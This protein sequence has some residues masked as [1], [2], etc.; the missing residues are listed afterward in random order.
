MDLLPALRAF[1]H[2]REAAGRNPDRPCGTRREDGRPGQ[3]AIPRLRNQRV[4]AYV[5]IGL[6]TGAPG[7]QRVR[8]RWLPL[9]RGQF[10]HVQPVVTPSP[11][12]YLGRSRAIAARAL[13]GEERTERT[14]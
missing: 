12:G 11:A 7:N 5:S 13:G 14:Y 9:P 1:K 3:T 6:D 8:S 10:A 2:S 4:D